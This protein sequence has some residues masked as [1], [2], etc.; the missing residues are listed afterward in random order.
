MHSNLIDLKNH[1]FGRLVVNSFI[2]KNNV[3]F[4]ECTCDCGT[5]KLVRGSSLRSGMTQSCGCL[6]KELL[7]N[8]KTHGMTHTLI[9]KT[10]TALMSRCFNPKNQDYERYAGRGITVCEFIRA[11]PLNLFLLIGDRPIGMEIDRIDNDSSYSCGSCAQCLK[12]G[13]KMNIRWETRKSQMRNTSKN[14][15]IRI[16]GVVQC[17]ADWAKHFAVPHAT[18]YYHFVPKNH[19]PGEIIEVSNEQLI[20]KGIIKP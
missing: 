11:T 16:N 18:F 6:R 8:P 12:N 17:V 20:K 9:F 3:I 14:K 4:W 19:T 13:W 15:N 7:K 1:R 10:W 5:I 2:H